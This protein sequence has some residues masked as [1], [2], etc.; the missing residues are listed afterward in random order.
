MLGNSTCLDVGNNE[1]GNLCVIITVSKAHS[2]GR[3]SIIYCMKLNTVDIV[4]TFEGHPFRLS[5][6]N[7]QYI[8]DN[9]EVTNEKIQFGSVVKYIEVGKEYL[10]MGNTERPRMV[11]SVL[12]S[13]L[14]RSYFV[15][16]RY[17]QRCDSKTSNV[18][19][20]CYVV[21]KTQKSA[22]PKY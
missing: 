13:N 3:T 15:L 10:Y 9:D 5:K 22:V 7:F 21:L 17:I 20:T 18:Q 2:S 8:W 11:S 16:I 19:N 6:R 1:T 12:S 14:P 4:D